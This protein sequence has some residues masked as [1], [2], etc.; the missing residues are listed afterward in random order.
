MD[1][2]PIQDAEELREHLGL[3]NE[4]GEM[5]VVV[6]WDSVPQPFLVTLVGP[7]AEGEVVLFDSP[8]QYDTDRKDGHTHCDECMGRYHGIKNLC[9][10]LVVLADS[11]VRVHHPAC[12]KYGDDS[13]CD[14]CNR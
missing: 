6:G 11:D 1:L 14:A 4:A 8:W 9:Y 3:L 10:P 7:Y 5:P 2:L 12:V 13:R